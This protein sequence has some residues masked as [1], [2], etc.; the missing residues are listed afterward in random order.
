MQILF[1]IINCVFCFHFLH[2]ATNWRVNAVLGTMFIW[3][4]FDISINIGKRQKKCGELV[5][6][7]IGCLFLKLNWQI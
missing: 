4:T 5:F 7:F 1:F 6:V 3:E 2:C